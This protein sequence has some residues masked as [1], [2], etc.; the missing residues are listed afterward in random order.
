MKNE[1]K[2]LTNNAPT[3][4]DALEFKQSKVPPS[5]PEVLYAWYTQSVASTEYPDRFKT[6]QTAFRNAINDKDYIRSLKQKSPS[7]ASQI[8]YLDTN[9]TRKMVNRR[10]KYIKQYVKLMEEGV[11]S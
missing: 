5:A 11:K 9:N 10:Q 7:I 8:Y 6:L 3:F 2:K 4:S 1:W